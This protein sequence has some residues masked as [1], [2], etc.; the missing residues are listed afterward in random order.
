M[1]IYRISGQTGAPIEVWA[2]E[3]RDYFKDDDGFGIHPNETH[4]DGELAALQ[5]LLE[6]AKTRVRIAECYFR[7]MEA[8]AAYAKSEAEKMR[9]RLAAV[10]KRIEEMIHG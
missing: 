7:R 6:R 5:A 10:E 8:S 9:A 3:F 2:D 1:W 4:F